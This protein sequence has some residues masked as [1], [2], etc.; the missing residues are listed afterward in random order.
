MDYINN[1]PGRQ[2]PAPNAAAEAMRFLAKEVKQASI[3]ELV[4][5]AKDFWMQQ[6]PEQPLYRTRQD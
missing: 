6:T 2:G 1:C 5:M 3:R 4:F